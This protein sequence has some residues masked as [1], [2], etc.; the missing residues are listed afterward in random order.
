MPK[1]IAAISL[2]GIKRRLKMADMIE[3]CCSYKILYTVN[4]NCVK[5]LCGRY[6]YAYY[7]RETIPRRRIIKSAAMKRNHILNDIIIQSLTHF[8]ETSHPPDWQNVM[9]AG[10]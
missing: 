6:K 8:T 4:Y 9:Y 2:K 1:T 10:Y 7:F 5:T 3:S